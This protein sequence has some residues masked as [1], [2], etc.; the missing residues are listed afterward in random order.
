MPS[1]NS[2]F[3]Q[4]SP[5]I[6]SDFENQSTHC[7]TFPSSRLVKPRSPWPLWTKAWGTVASLS[8]RQPQALHLEGLEDDVSRRLREGK[9]STAFPSGR[10]STDF[11]N[12]SSLHSACPGRLPR[13]L[14]RHR[15]SRAKAGSAKLAPHVAGLARR[16]DR[17]CP[18]QPARDMSKPI[19]TELQPRPHL[20]ARLDLPNRKKSA[21]LVAPTTPG[22]APP[23]CAHP[24]PS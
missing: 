7:P 4:D 22:E 9:S 13:D 12:P 18:S 2:A 11:E 5:V 14:G 6:S 16:A 3:P 8:S 24:S 23:A 21:Q 20:Q 17:V 10:L 15:L 1:A 19:V